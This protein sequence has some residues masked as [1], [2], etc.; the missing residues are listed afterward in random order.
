MSR[1]CPSG[2]AGHA[3]VEAA[4]FSAKAFSIEL[5]RRG[6]YSDDLYAY[7]CGDCRRWHTTRRAEWNGHVNRI[8]YVAPSRELQRWAMGRAEEGGHKEG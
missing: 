2:K 8:V 1:T 3:S 6:L 7:R 5:N 4:A